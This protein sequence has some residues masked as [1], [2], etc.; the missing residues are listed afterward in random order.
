[1]SPIERLKAG[2]R[3]TQIVAAALPLFSRKGFKAT[4]TREIAEAAGVSEALLYKHFPSK[5]SIYR[6]MSYA[7][8]GE[9]VHEVAQRLAQLE[10]GTRSLVLAI[11]FLMI[12]ILPEASPDEE[13]KIQTRRVMAQSLLEDGEF[14]RQFQDAR[15][16]PF[17]PDLERFVAASAAAGDF[18]D[19][20][21][22]PRVRVLLCQHLACGTAFM[23]MPETKPLDYGA[24]R[25]QVNRE[26]VLFV[27]RGLGLK[28]EAIRKHFE[29]AE[30]DRLIQQLQPEVKS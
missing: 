1:V 21:A 10:A 30:F 5:D 9:S 26:A 16:I 4:T 17:I 8:C 25:A 19:T 14:A 23:S 18:V 13:I 3:K 28:D 7:L 29:P 2:D 6:E 24:T 11:Y 12:A 20:P 22:F 15:V 27:L